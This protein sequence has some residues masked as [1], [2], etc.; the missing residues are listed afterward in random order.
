M[1]TDKRERQRQ[2]RAV[3][4]VELN[5]VNRREKVLSTAKRV[6]IWVVVFF[7]LLIVANAVWG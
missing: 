4:Q 1:A 5:K 7:V 6:A 3:K 2:N